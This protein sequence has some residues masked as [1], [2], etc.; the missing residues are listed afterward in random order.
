M[1]KEAFG[2][3]GF[4][5]SDQCVSGRWCSCRSRSNKTDNACSGGFSSDVRLVR[6]D[7][8][9]HEQVLACRR[10]LLDVPGEES[11]VLWWQ[12]SFFALFLELSGNLVCRDCLVLVAP[13]P[14][15]M[16]DG[17]AIRHRK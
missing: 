8:S 13:P 4:F 10:I 9:G 16:Q 1:E 12:L 17:A 5:S 3:E 6:L 14:P 2:F 15:L 7:P 11:A